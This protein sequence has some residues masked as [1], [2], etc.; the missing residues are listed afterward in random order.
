MKW[1][2]KKLNYTIRIPDLGPEGYTLLGGRLLSDQSGPAAFL[3]FQNGKGER[4]MLMTST[5][6]RVE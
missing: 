4:L 6:V 2:S 1:L 3:M 5:H